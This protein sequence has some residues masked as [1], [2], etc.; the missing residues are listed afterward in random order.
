MDAR[1]PLSLVR[2]EVRQV[3]VAENVDH[4]VDPTGRVPSAEDTVDETKPFARYHCDVVD[5][6]IGLRVHIRLPN[7]F[8]RGTM[9]EEADAARARRLRQ[10]RD[11]DSTAALAIESQMDQLY[12]DMADD[13]LRNV[14]LGKAQPLATARAQVDIEHA[15]HRSQPDLKQYHGIERQQMTYDRLLRAGGQETEEFKAV[16]ELLM[17]Y[18]LVLQDRVSDLLEPLKLKLQNV[19]R[20]GLLADIRKAIM[21][22]SC[23]SAFMRAYSQWQVYFGTR[24]FEDHEK[25][26]FRSFEALMDEDGQ[27]VDRL[28]AEFAT[29]E[30]INID[31]MRRFLAAIPS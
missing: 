16:E 26:Y 12:A 13:E 30:A 18:A 8:Q 28:M 19:D 14:L 6:A 21:R 3:E 5:E 20:D 11:S 24:D 2:Q 7:Q 29:L 4:D 1:P 27:K 17:D 10:L 31:E 23:D 22:E 25:L 15:D 9:K